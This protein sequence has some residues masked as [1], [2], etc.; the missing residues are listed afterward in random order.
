MRNCKEQNTYENYV[1]L[2]KN[3]SLMQLTPTIIIQLGNEF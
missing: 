2:P 1:K 3:F